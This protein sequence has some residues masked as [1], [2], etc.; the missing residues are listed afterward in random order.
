M[1]A[2]LKGTKSSQQI[3]NNSFTSEFLRWSLLSLDLDRSSV[4]NR[5]LSKVKN[6]IVNSV[7]PDDTVCYKQFHLDLHRFHRYWFWSAGLNE[8]NGLRRYANIEFT[9][10]MKKPCVLIKLTI[11]DSNM[12]VYIHSAAILAQIIVYCLNH[13]N[14]WIDR[15]FKASLQVIRV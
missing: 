8:L 7:D 14:H 9:E 12:F 4:S 11:C 6:G 10:E 2:S 1:E 13:I 5:C 15:L 3:G